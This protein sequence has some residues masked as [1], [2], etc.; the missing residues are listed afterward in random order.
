MS[1]ARDLANAGTALGAV[2]ATELGYVDGVTSAIQT[3]IDGKQA[4]NANVSTTEL[5]YLDGVTSAVQTQLDAK[6]IKATLT[7]KGDIYAATAAS[8]PDRLAVGANDTVLTADSTAATGLK[9]ATPAAGG[10]TLLSTTTLSGASTTISSIAQTYNSLVAYIYA[11]NVSTGSQLRIGPNAATT[12]CS[13]SASNDGTTGTTSDYNTYFQPMG[14][15][16]LVTGQSGV[17][18]LT[19]NNYSSTTTWKPMSAS[20]SIY[21]TPVGGQAGL[22]AWGSFLSTT[23][24]SSLVFSLSTG[25]FSAGTVLLYGVK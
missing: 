3:Q 24:I 1:K 9:W 5:G 14:S 15:G 12:G 13:Y 21:W 19:I 17:W 16:S 20:G 8:T 4:I 2:T 23:A 18:T 11:I 25:T 7:T 10:M 22:R 6:T